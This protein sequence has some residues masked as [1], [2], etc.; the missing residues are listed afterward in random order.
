MKALATLCGVF[1]FLTDAFADGPIGPPVDNRLMNNVRANDAIRRA[2]AES[3]ARAA[4][5]ER[6]QQAA[7]ARARREAEAAAEAAYRERESIER[8]AR[9]EREATN[10]QRLSRLASQWRVVNGRKSSLVDPPW[11]FVSGKVLESH[12]EGMRVHISGS[13][14]IWLTNFPYAVADNEA[15]SEH[16]QEI[17]LHRYTTVLGATATLRKYDCGTPIEEPADSKR[18]RLANEK[19]EE[20]RAAEEDRQ[21]VERERQAAAERA[22]RANAAREAREAQR[23]ATLQRVI[24]LQQQQASNGLPS[25]QF[26]LGKRY[27]TGDGVEMN[28]ILARHWLQSACTNGSSLASNLLN[29]ISRPQEGVSIQVVK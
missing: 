6:D 23:I 21:A 28:Q 26:E 25:F 22:R 12:P 13:E 10:R 1:L 18:L 16:A 24:V 9:R 5:Y 19:A 27:L 7:V 3:E 15:I 17:G 4:A 29:H 8:N 2:Q 14:T 11:R 20:E